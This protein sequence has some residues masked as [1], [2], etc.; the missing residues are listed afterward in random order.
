MLLPISLRKIVDIPSAA[1][2]C[3]LR[4]FIDQN[5]VTDR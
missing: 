1:F 2:Y 5:K 3:H 4:R